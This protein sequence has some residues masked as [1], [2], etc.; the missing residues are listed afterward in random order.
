MALLA[1]LEIFLQNFT[2]LFTLP[3]RCDTI[4]SGGRTLR[5]YEWNEEMNMTY[6]QTMKKAE[7]HEELAFTGIY[8]GAYSEYRKGSGLC[9][10]DA[11]REEKKRHEFKGYKTRIIHVPGGVELYIEHK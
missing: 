11:L 6:K 1:I 4:E 8:C 10:S 7:L 2:K 9:G 3:V 5:K